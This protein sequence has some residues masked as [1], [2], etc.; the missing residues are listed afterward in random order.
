[1]PMRPPKI[2]RIGGC[3]ELSPTGFCEKHKAGREPWRGHGGKSSTERGYGAAWR[4]LR[5]IV[6]RRDLFKCV[7]CKKKGFVTIATEVDHIINKSKGGTDDLENLQ[8]I[9][10]PCHIEKTNSESH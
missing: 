3:N 4:K 8:S 5:D 6:L 1:M 10:N 9:C 7:P 2:C